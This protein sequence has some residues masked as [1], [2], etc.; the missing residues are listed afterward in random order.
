MRKSLVTM[1]LVLAISAASAMTVFAGWEGT[2]NSWKYNF[3]G[4]YFNDGWHWIDGN[5]DGIA[6]CYYFN[7]DSIMS[8]N[9]TTPDGYTVDTTGAWTVNGVVQVKYLNASHGTSN[10]GAEE[11]RRQEES[12]QAEQTQPTETTEQVLEVP[13]SGAVET[14]PSV[15]PTE[16]KGSS[17][18]PSENAA[19]SQPS[20]TPAPS[21]GSGS[22]FPEGSPFQEV[23]GAIGDATGVRDPKGF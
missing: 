22:P 13:E 5:N 1:G 17:Q 14:E 8:A 20:T 19:P 6:E 3:N 10:I 11:R 9:T 21:T 16:S 4:T 15:I 7:A 2:G 18:A 12:R 23:G